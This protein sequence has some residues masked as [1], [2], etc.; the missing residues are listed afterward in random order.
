MSIQL[1]PTTL[2]GIFAF[3]EDGLYT[4]LKHTLYEENEQA[5]DS[6][7]DAIHAHTDGNTRSDA[8]ALKEKQKTVSQLFRMTYPNVLPADSHAK[9]KTSVSITYHTGGGE[10]GGGEPRDTTTKRT[11]STA[12][13]ALATGG[14]SSSSSSA[15]TVQK[16]F[17]E[18]GESLAEAMWSKPALATYY[19]AL[20]GLTHIVLSTPPSSSSSSSS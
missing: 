13:A 5:V 7:L 10:G 12:G 1:P 18:A 11:R 20:K 14:S 2:S 6:A 4:H 16:L 9:R 3:P 19:K 15:R 8:I 17:E